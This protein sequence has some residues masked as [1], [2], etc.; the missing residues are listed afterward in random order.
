[1][2]PATRMQETVAGSSLNVAALAAGGNAQRARHYHG[3][4]LLRLIA[5]SLVV[6]FHVSEMGGKRPS[7][8]VDAADAPLGWLHPIAWM[9]WIGV[10]IFFVLSG[11]LIAASAVNSTQLRFLRKRTIRIFPALWISC[12]ISL[13]ARLLWGE[14]LADLLP[15]MLRSAFLS[16]KGPY[17]DGV[18]W[19]LVVEAAFYLVVAT[20][21]WLSRSKKGAEAML[22]RTAFA[23][24]LAST[25]FAILQA[26]VAQ[27]DGTAQLRTL[28]HGFVFDVLL[29]R[30]GM[31]FAIGMLLFHLIDHRPTPGT[32]AALGMFAIAACMQIA[33]TTAGKGDALVPV[34]IWAAATALMFASVKFPSNQSVGGRLRFSRDLGLMTYPLYLNHFVL[35]QALMPL[36]VL[37]LPGAAI[38][39]VLFVALLANAWLIAM[40]PERWVQDWLAKVIARTAAQPGRPEASKSGLL[41]VRSRR[42]APAGD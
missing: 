10:Q 2:N 36:L 8:P 16:P 11:F 26:V 3:P 12:A 37:W 28:L 19:S 15:A 33:E 40:Y 6:L 14:P 17:L 38:F 20:A 4:D 22:V 32:V 39:P 9:G 5:A 41:S 42:P 18:V 29:L 21:I 13:V 1:M 34:T 7:W 31:F 24:G 23:I 30:Q 25:G 27:L 35:A